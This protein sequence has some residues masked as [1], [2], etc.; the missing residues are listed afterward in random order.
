[1]TDKQRAA[2]EKAQKARAEQLR[3][4]QAKREKERKEQDKQ[5]RIDE[6][7]R[8]LEE[9][10]EQKRLAREERQNTKR[11]K[12]ATPTPTPTPTRSKR[13]KP[14]AKAQPAAIRPSKKKS[15]ILKFGDDEPFFDSRSPFFEED[16]VEEDN[17]GG[18]FG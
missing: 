16:N 1:M 9:E 3:L 11:G 7:K 17:Y 18:I 6:A 5:R 10:K 4:M 8:I 13:S 12:K 2:L 15:V 14:A